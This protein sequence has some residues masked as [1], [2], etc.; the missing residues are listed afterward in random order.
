MHAYP[1]THRRRRQL[2][3]RRPVQA[4]HVSTGCVFTTIHLFSLLSLR[5]LYAYNR[6]RYVTYG[7]IYRLGF[8]AGKQQVLIYIYIFSPLVL[9]AVIYLAHFLG[10]FFLFV[11]CFR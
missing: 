8:Y 11:R 5:A 2:P 1:P 4:A 6:V 3:Y 9:F 7:Y 10:V